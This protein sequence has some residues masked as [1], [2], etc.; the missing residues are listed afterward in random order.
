VLERWQ[1]GARK[2][3]LPKGMTGWLTVLAGAGTI[4]GV[5]FHAGQC[6]T[7][8]GDA[9]LQADAGSDLLFAYPGDSRI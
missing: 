8:E 7:I 1:G 3:T 9:A 2:V 6:L 4:D 5:D